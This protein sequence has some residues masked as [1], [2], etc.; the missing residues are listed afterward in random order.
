M[1]T[2]LKFT[3][4][5]ETEV[6]TA[7]GAKAHKHKITLHA[8]LTLTA[9]RRTPNEIKTQTQNKHSSQTEKQITRLT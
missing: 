4:G 7:Q 8:S 1:T 5:P 6:K 3:K 2:V 9:Q